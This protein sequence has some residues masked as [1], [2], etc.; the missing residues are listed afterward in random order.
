MQ[1]DNAKVLIKFIININNFQRYWIE[2]ITA[3]PSRTYYFSS[4]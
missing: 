4:F 3:K 1:K 2:I